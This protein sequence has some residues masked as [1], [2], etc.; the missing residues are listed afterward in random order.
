MNSIVKLSVSQFCKVT[1]HNRSL[2]SVIMLQTERSDPYCERMICSAASDI[3]RLNACTALRY[4]SFL[5]PQ[6]IR[7]KTDTTVIFFKH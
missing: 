6:N 1:Q 7:Y 2:S 3:K 5:K 4:A